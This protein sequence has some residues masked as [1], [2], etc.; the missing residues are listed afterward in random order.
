M[1]RTIRMVPKTWEHPQDRRGE[2]VPLLLH[3]YLICNLQDFED[4]VKKYGLEKT[5]EDWGSRPDPKDYMPDFDVETMTHYQ[6]YESVSEG[7]PISPPMLTPEKLAR[8]L[9]D[10]NANPGGGPGS[11]ASYDAWLYVCKTGYAPSMALVAG[12]GVVDGVTAIYEMRKEK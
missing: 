2:Y 6:M 12:V 1:G 9:V 10:N 4:D 8:W 3:A 11:S 5:L 7:T